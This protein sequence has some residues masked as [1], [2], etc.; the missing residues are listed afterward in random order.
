MKRSR[1]VV[2]AAAWAVMGLVG[3]S[4]LLAQEAP[5]PPPV[6]NGAVSL[7]LGTDIATHY[8]FRGVLQED[9]GVIVQ[10][11]A[12]IGFNLFA[13]DGA[14]NSLDLT[15]GTWS[16]LHSEHTG[17]SGTNDIFYETDYYAGISATVFEKWTAGVM[18]YA[19]TSPNNAFE[20]VQEIGLSL[21]F[22]DADLIAE[23][24]AL[25]PY[26]L[27]VFEVDNSSAGA[28]EGIYLEL[29]FEPSFVILQSE[30][31]PVTLSIPVAVGLSLDDYYSEDIAFVRDG[32]SFGFVK[33]G[34]TLSVPLSFIPA[35]FGEWTA[36][37]GADC[38]FLGSDQEAANN[39][40]DIELVGRL[41]IS[42][43]Y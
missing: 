16:S 12:E 14:F 6:N 17:S 22:N 25:N 39:G 34:V 41:G 13:G 20:T 32:D 36:A 2:T 3:S 15:I 29:G 30:D 8:F 40:D 33:A 24:L 1:I 21:S 9:Q 37:L 19:Y 27:L 31:Y 10:P 11:Y 43:S 7:T 23:G 42:M 4:S 26:A 18:Y 35:E 5:A 38:Y 28:D